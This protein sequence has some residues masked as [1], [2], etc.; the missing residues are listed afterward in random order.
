M[1]ND[2]RDK[3]QRT[4]HLN[5]KAKYHSSTMVVSFGNLRSSFQQKNVTYLDHSET[6]G[7]RWDLKTVLKTKQKQKLFK[8]T[9][10]PGYK[11][12]ENT[13]ILMR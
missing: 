5:L 6:N 7:K 11:K 12:N 10:I 2:E 9:K 13:W 3:I 8:K 4:E 1:L